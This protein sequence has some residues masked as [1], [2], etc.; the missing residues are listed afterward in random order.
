M[1]G[2]LG[3]Q[4]LRNVLIQLFC[5]EGFFFVCVF[6]NLIMLLLHRELSCVYRQERI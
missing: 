2:S 4:L 3:Q 1:F 6:V 5:Y